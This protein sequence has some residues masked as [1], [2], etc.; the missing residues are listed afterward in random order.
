MK[1]FRTLLATLACSLTLVTAWPAAYASAAVVPRSSDAD[2]IDAARADQPHPPDRCPYLKFNYGWPPSEETRACVRYA[3]TGRKVLVVGDSHAEHW[4]PALR[5]VARARNWRLR[6]L[7]RAGC[8]PLNYVAVR[9]WDSRDP[10]IGEQCYDWRHTAYPTVI[11]DFDP[12]LVLFGG[13]SQAYDIQLDGRIIRR[14]GTEWFQ[15]WRRSWRWTVRTLRSSGATLGALELQPTMTHDVPNCLDRY[16]LRTQ[17]CDMPLSDDV[18]TARTNRFVDNIASVY[19]GVRPVRFNR[20]LCPSGTC[21]A[22][23]DGLIT[24]ADNAHLTGRWS[25]AQHLGV[26]DR[27]RGAGLI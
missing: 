1:P 17:R 14:P 5:G 21:V 19:S 13:R 11:A 2:V 18:L 22:V 24:H 27:L 25:A 26:R 16:G 6:S 23:D 12:D 3:G 4:M 8:S 20:L 15:E 9:S 10:S 7:T